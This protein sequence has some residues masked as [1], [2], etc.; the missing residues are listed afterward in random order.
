MLKRG[1]WGKELKEQVREPGGGEEFQAEGTASA[2]ALR[3]EEQRLVGLQQSEGTNEGTKRGISDN[4][5]QSSGIKGVPTCGDFGCD[6]VSLTKELMQVG[7]DH[8]CASLPGTVV[9]TEQVFSHRAA[10][11][12]NTQMKEEEEYD[13]PRGPNLL[14][15]GLL[16]APQEPGFQS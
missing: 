12:M 5:E 2:K 15:R 9:G 4:E 11:R 13:A 3:Q 6:Y 16:S 7:Q 8:C 10:E 14:G 1:G